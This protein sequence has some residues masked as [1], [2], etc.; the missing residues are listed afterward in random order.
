MAVISGNKNPYPTWQQMEPGDCDIIWGTKLRKKVYI[1]SSN[2]KVGS[3]ALL[4]ES[5]VLDNISPVSA[6]CLFMSTASTLK[7]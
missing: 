3:P 6:Q 4:D 7:Q 1:S 5:R 2:V